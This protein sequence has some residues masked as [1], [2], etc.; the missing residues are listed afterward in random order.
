MKILKQEKMKNSYSMFKR[1]HEAFLNSYEFIF[2]AFS[3]EQFT[4]GMKKLGLNNSELDKINSIGSGGYILKSKSDEF[5]NMFNSFSEELEE[6]MKNYEF[7]VDAFKYELA[8]HE[9]GYTYDYTDTL[10]VF[11]LDYET[12]TKEQH[13]ALIQARKEILKND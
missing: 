2:Y 8:N 3:K 10:N 4:E 11:G 6:N 1:K 7:L 5:L 9:F 13:R 12:L